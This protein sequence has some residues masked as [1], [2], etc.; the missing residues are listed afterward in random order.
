[1]RP[2]A[3]VALEPDRWSGGGVGADR[4][5]PHPGVVACTEAVRVVDISETELLAGDVSKPSISKF[6]PGLIP[7]RVLCDV[8]GGAI[9]NEK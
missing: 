8:L 9:L 3:V 2:E 5:G 7:L 4:R 1:M 6:R